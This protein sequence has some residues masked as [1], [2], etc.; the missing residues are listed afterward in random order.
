MQRQ[1]GYWRVALHLEHRG[2]GAGDSYSSLLDH[3]QPMVAAA[4]PPSL[5]LVL[6]P[7]GWLA[8]VSLAVCLLLMQLPMTLAMVSRQGPAM[9]AF[10]PLGA[11]RAIWRAVGMVG[12][13]LNRMLGRGGIAA[14]S[15]HA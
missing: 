5:I 12:G 15:S 1:Q 6:L 2:H 4:L 7:W 3:L 8:P 10:M 13:V 14:G 11:I 9:F